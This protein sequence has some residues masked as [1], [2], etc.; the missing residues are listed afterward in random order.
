M[1]I[2]GPSSFERVSP[3]QRKWLRTGERDARGVQPSLPSFWRKLLL[4]LLIG[5]FGCQFLWAQAAGQDARA[6]GAIDVR[7]MLPDG[8]HFNGLARV[9]LITPDGVEAAEGSVDVTGH[10]T[11]QGLIPATYIVEASAPGFVPVR[12]TVQLETKWSQVTVMLTMKPEE[13]EKAPSTKLAA[14]VLAPKAR[15]ELEKGLEA[16]RRKDIAEARKDFEKALA[17]APGDPDVQF[18]MGV[19]ELEVKNSAAAEDHLQKAIQIFPNHVAALET[20]GEFYCAQGKVQAALPL[21]EKGVSLEEGSWKAHWRLGQAYL[22]AKEPAK[23]LAQAESAVGMGKSAA[24][25]AQIL[26]AQAL[27]ALGKWDQAEAT[28]EKFTADQ[29]NDPSSEKA[30]AVLAEIKQR[31]MAELEKT[32]IPQTALAGFNEISELRPRTPGL[33]SLSWEPPGIDDFVPT[34]QADVPCSLPHVLTG[35]SKTVVELMDNIEKFSAKEEVKHYPVDKFG[36]MHAP[37]VR[38]YEYVATVT[39]VNGIVQLEEYRDGSLSPELFPAHIATEG[40]PAM[41]LVFH[42]QMSVDFRFVCEGLGSAEGRPAWQVHFEQRPDRPSRMRAYVIGG[43]YYSV[44]IKGRAWIDANSFQLV[45]LESESMLRMPNI[46]LRRDQVDIIYAPVKFRS[47]NL[48]LWLPRS[49]EVFVEK[50]KY[51]YYRTHAFSDFQIFS[52]GTNQKIQAPKESYSFTNLSNKEILGRLTITPVMERSI[53]P[54]SITFTIPPQASVI[55]T[56]GRGKDLD[57]PPD[58]IASARFVYQGAPGIVEGDALLTNAS[59]LEI[60]PESQLPAAARN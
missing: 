51:A 55:K 41:A 59:T 31:E 43:N 27:A 25:D 17:M 30:R 36:Q 12:E 45:R 39:Q 24:G 47:R 6:K 23:A 52:V 57:I 50:E 26:K 37:Q 14:P 33:R 16:F 22:Q 60:V 15:K 20:L 32:V 4:T 7:L 13:T 40:L 42:P 46:Q 1:G 56:V 28:L 58:W 38:S 11:I 44:P 9:R 34:V 53:T 48:E 3:S 18:L 5:L 54:I 29:P 49:A 35:A 21:L 2:T 8:K 19:L 10:T